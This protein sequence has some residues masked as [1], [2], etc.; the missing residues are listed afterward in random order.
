MDR[1]VTATIEVEYDKETY[2]SSPVI[3]IGDKK[4]TWEEFGKEIETFE[5]WRFDFKLSSIVEV[6]IITLAPTF[7][8][9]AIES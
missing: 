2:N 3:V 8:P 9:G 5:G 6:C 4:Y 7:P 1:E